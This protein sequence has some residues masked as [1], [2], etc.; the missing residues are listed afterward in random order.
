MDGSSQD[1]YL[2]EQGGY[3]RKSED[4]VWSDGGVSPNGTSRTTSKTYTDADGTVITEYRTERNGTITVRIERRTRVVNEQVDD[5]DHDQ[6]LRDAIRQVTDMNP[7]LDVEK[8]EI[9]T[10]SEE[11][12]DETPDYSLV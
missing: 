1:D 5:Y 4:G 7:D 2:S 9:H 6:A 3:A 8:I 10:K 11:H 12:Y